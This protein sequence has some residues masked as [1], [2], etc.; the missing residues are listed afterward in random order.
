MQER[1]LKGETDGRCSLPFPVHLLPTSYPEALVVIFL[2]GPPCNFEVK[3]HVPCVLGEEDGK[4]LGFSLVLSQYSRQI[5]LISVL[6]YVCEKEI[7][8]IFLLGFQLCA[9]KFYLQFE[10]T[11]NLI[12]FSKKY[13]HV[14]IGVSEF[15]LEAR[16]WQNCI[17]N[18]I[19][20]TIENCTENTIE[21]VLKMC[22]CCLV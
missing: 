9:L 12:I 3:I 1:L 18:C 16:K 20:N 21:I 5:L 11:V 7:K 22:I 15:L 4:K 6:L 10:L 14:V 13:N 8:L 17:E 2:P 19:E